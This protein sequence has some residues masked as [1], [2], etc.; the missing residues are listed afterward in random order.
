MQQFIAALYQTWRL[1]ALHPLDSDWWH[2][3]PAGGW[4]QPARPSTCPRG[5]WISEGHCACQIAGAI[6]EATEKWKLELR[7]RC[8]VHSDWANTWLTSFSRARAC[9]IAARAVSHSS[10]EG[11]LT[12]WRT[13][14][15]PR[16]FWYLI[17]LSA[18]SRSS[19]DEWRK[20]L[21][22]PLRATSSRSKCAACKGHWTWRSNV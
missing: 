17:S 18:C 6:G 12:G 16:R 5:N 19:S 13:T 15:P 20:N 8:I 3:W 7:L 14:L 2:I 22:N 21:A 9:S 11:L 10:M 1:R 4:T